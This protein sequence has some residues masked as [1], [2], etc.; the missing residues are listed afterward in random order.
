MNKKF[1]GRKLFSYFVEMF[2]LKMLLSRTKQERFQ[3]K[4]LQNRRIT[5]TQEHPN[6]PW[7]KSC[8]CG[9]CFIFLQRKT[10]NSAGSFNT[11]KNLQLQTE[12]LNSFGG[13]PSSF[14]KWSKVSWTKDLSPISVKSSSKGAAGWSVLLFPLFVLMELSPCRLMSIVKWIPQYF[15]FQ[16]NGTFQRKLLEIL[17]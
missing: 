9:C 5:D 15:V 6:L 13:A 8:T 7:Q 16:A 14:N 2:Y 11:Q 1:I 10:W 4:R 17:D 12:P 3:K